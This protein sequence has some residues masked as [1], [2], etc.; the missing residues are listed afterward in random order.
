[1][2]VCI[3]DVTKNENGDQHAIPIGL[4]Q[5]EVDLITNATK[6]GQRTQQST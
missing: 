4:Q 5:G 3:A 1:M 2:S 6:I